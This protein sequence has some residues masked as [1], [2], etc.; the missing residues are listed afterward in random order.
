MGPHDL[1][2]KHISE[3][4]LNMPQMSTW[5][6]DV[7]LNG[8]LR[9]LPQS[10]RNTGAGRIVSISVSLFCHLDQPVATSLQKLVLDSFFTT[11]STSTTSI[12]K[13]PSIRPVIILWQVICPLT[14]TLDNLGPPFLI[15]SGLSNL[16]ADLVY[17]NCLFTLF[18]RDLNVRRFIQNM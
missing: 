13:N 2:K 14:I 17:S 5:L 1:R 7:V 8:N 18:T 11:I 4:L 6:E 15:R 10:S 16:S 9:H 3:H 12:T